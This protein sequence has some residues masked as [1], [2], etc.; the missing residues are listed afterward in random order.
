MSQQLQTVIFSFPSSGPR[1]WL[2]LNSDNQEPRVV[3]MEQ[4]GSS[5]WSASAE[6]LP[7]EYHCRFYCGDDRNVSYC[8]PATIQGSLGGGMDSLVSVSHADPV[9]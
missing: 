7:G 3:E 8:G 6:L 9:V 2:V 4:A 5:V 1:A